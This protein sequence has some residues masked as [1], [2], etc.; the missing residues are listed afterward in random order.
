MQVQHIAQ[1]GMF[2]VQL[3]L[4]GQQWYPQRANLS[5]VDVGCSDAIESR[6][7]LFPPRGR[8][9]KQPHIKWIDFT[10]S[11]QIHE[12]ADICSFL[13]QI[14][15]KSILAKSTS[16]G[17]RHQE[18]TC[19]DSASC[20]IVIAIRL[21]THRLMKLQ[22]RFGEVSL[23]NGE[24]ST[25]EMSAA[26]SRDDG[27]V[28]EVFDEVTEGNIAYTTRPLATPVTPMPEACVPSL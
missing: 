9:E 25:R 15:G 4:L 2:D 14:H 13:S 27:T 23:A 5:E 10:E 6:L 7:D 1:V 28:G 12:A 17:T 19:L 16:A 20:R 3:L 8:S 21:D 22:P 24:D 11:N 18:I 26:T